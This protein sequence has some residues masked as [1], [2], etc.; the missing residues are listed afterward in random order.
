MKLITKVVGIMIVFDTDEAT[1][2]VKITTTV[3]CY[4]SSRTAVIITPSGY[5]AR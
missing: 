4:I 5:R 2:L 1:G 3:V